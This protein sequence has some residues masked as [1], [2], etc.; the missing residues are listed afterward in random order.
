MSGAAV[1]V[2]PGRASKLRLDHRLAM[3][4]S[5]ADLLDRKLRILSAELVALRNA[6][7]ETDLQWRAA[8]ADADQRLLDASLLGGQR[9]IRLAVPRGFAEVNV[10]Y[11]VTVGVRHPAGASFTPP[12]EPAPWSGQAV[13]EARQA[14]QAAVTAAVTHAAA[15]AAAHAIET[16]VT[17]TRIRLRAVRDRL[18]PRLQEALGRLAL[19]IDEQ[20]REDAIRL[21]LAESARGQMGVT[22]AE[23]RA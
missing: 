3:A 14:Q 23:P 16:E 4:T 5:G 22:S 13:D 8:A 12:R 7:S 20:E 17:A 11:E 15:A 2:P 19:A 21:R 6:A 18:V 1:S 9:A 10:T